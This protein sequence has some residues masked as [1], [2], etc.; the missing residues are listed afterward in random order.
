MYVKADSTTFVL[1]IFFQL[2]AWTVIIDVIQIFI[3]RVHIG[4]CYTDNQGQYLGAIFIGKLCGTAPV[5]KG[6]M[7]GKGAVKFS[8]CAVKMRQKYKIMR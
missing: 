1:V 5:Q 2:V 3:L 4:F 6:K 8:K 7:C